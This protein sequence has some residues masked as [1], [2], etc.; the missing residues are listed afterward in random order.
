MKWII[1]LVVLILFEGLADYFA[2]KWGI[3]GN[4]RFAIISFTGYAVGNL[5][6]LIAMHNG[7]GLVRGAE[8]FSIVSALLAITIGILIYKENLSTTQI[9]GVILGIIS[10]VLLVWKTN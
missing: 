10:I 9:I 5:S 1:P 8:I 7:S 6:W 4:L 3:T 2:G